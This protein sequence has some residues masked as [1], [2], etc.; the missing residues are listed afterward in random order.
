ML[1][2]LVLP[3]GGLLGCG[4]F[5]DRRVAGKPASAGGVV[6][7]GGPPWAGL[8]AGSPVVLSAAVYGWVRVGRAC[9]IVFPLVGLGALDG[10]WFYADL[11]IRRNG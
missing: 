1:L 2:R 7:C 9:D 3:V 4:H 8:P 6:L 10:R 11:T 5:R